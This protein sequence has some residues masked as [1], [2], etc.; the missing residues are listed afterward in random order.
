MTDNVQKL[1]L[2]FG[3]GMIMT[4]VIFLLVYLDIKKGH[5]KK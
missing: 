2:V 5:S 1:K 4:L 3:S